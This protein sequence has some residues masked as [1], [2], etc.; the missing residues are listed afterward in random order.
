[1]P[2]LELLG[3]PVFLELFGVEP[4]EPYA[5]FKNVW[6]DHPLPAYKLAGLT[7]AFIYR[8]EEVRL[9]RNG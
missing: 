7:L 1:M 9:H 2:T 8:L 5:T 4:A 3:E 6:F